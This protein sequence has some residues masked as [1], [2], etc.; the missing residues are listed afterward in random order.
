MMCFYTIPKALSNS[1]SEWEYRELDLGELTR[2]LLFIPS[3]VA[4]DRYDWCS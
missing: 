4:R 2:G 1:W 3:C